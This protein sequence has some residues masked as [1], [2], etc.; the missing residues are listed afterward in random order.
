MGA[1][2][3]P[4]VLEAAAGADVC[5]AAAVGAGAVVGTGAGGWVAGAAAGGAAVGAADG[6]GEHA[7]SKPTPAPA[8]RPMNTNERRLRRV[9]SLTNYSS[10]LILRKRPAH[11]PGT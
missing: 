10:P 1:T 11:L 3:W 5:T 2:G 6:V 9:F 8:T 4:L 7:A